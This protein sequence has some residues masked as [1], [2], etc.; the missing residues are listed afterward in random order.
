MRYE[1][2]QSP[3]LERLVDFERMSWPSEL[4]ATPEELRVRLETFSEGIF[5]LVDEG[6]DVAQVTVSPKAVPSKDLIVI[7]EAMRDLPV[8]RSSKILWVTNIATGMKSVGKGYGTKLL[9]G[10]VS[11]SIKA[12][13]EAIMAGVTCYGFAK[14]L[15]NRE[16]RSIQE[17]ME[18]DL[19]PA[20]RVFRASAEANGC[21]FSS[22][23][24]LA[25]YW[26]GD[27]ES[28]GYAVLVTIDLLS[29]SSSIGIRRRK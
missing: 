25:D 11:W 20:V 18:R 12:G 21:G 23:T 13:F 24:P 29:C 28:A 27:K 9:E 10:V 15:Q 6:E 2:I 7:F 5:L 16:V 17:F 14:A 3:V 8:D 19:N 22:G 1:I 26:S 4:Q